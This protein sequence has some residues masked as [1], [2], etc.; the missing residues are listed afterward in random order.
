[1]SLARD[2][3]VGCTAYPLLE[4]AARGRTHWSMALAGG[5]SLMWLRVVSKSKSP[6]AR[7]ALRGGAGITAIEYHIG[8]RLNRRHQV[9]DYRGM[10]LH[11]KGQ[12][13]APYS[14][15]WCL[16]S[17]GVLAYMKDS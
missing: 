6:L 13:C 8:K 2:F 15:L 9:W 14:A 10:P 12:I 3:K 1:M 7:K 4:L 17:A 11:Y 5:F 16:L